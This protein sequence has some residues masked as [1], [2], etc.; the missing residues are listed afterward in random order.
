MV[1]TYFKYS[2]CVDLHNQARQFD[3]ALEKK[4]VTHT[5]YFRLYTTLIGMVVTDIWKLNRVI[6]GSKETINE[7]ADL[8]AGDLLHNKE[9]VDE[10][11]DVIIEKGD[12][13]ETAE[14]SMS[15][16]TIGECGGRVH[17]KEFLKKQIRCIWCSRVNL[18]ER[19][20]LLKCMECGKGFCREGGCWSHHVALGGCP[21]APKKGTK[22]RLVSQLYEDG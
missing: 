10:E 13:E 9:K 17:T 3:L 1:S 19:K 4:W 18:V 11:I 14:T 8:L 20:T 2:N 15:S 7:Y 12:D 5:G 22:K 6:N 16:V 21:Q